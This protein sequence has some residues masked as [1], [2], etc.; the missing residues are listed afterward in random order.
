MALPL[1]YNWRNLFVRKTT[2]L[3]TVLVIA[4]VAGVLTWMWG[5][6]GALRRSLAVAGDP[7]TLIIIKNGATSESNSAVSIEDYNK[8]SQLSDIA[9]D[10]AGE[11]LQSPEMMVQVSLP[12]VRD[13]GRTFANVAVRGVTFAAFKVHRN[14][15]PLGAVFGTGVPEVIVGQAAAQQFDIKIGDTLSLGYGGDRGYKVVG[16]FSADGGP[17]ESEIWGYLP[18]LMNSYNR[19]MYSSANLLLTPGTDPQHTVEQIKGPAIQLTAIPEPEYWQSQAAFIRVYLR[20]AYALVGIMGVAAIFS[21]ANTMF[22]S[23]AGRTREIAML[24]TI[25]FGGRQILLGFLIEA[26]FLALMGG[27]LGCLGCAAWLRFVGSTKDMFGATT[28]TT[29][30]FQ[31]RLTPMIIAGALLAVSAVGMLGAL[32]PARRAARVQVVAALREP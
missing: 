13:Q 12:R 27:A 25:G 24:R 26:V 9:H 16:L 17:L 20:I 10:A 6:A 18:A 3:L 11:I 1:S 15:R 22:S 2:T 30:A 32:F 5:F 29:L 21:I 7:H 31:I 28:F 4:A 19:T 23:V 14:V 8:L